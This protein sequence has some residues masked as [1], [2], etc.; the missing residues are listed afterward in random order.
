MGP[1]EIA[2]AVNTSVLAGRVQS[3][4]QLEVWIQLAALAG[5]A[6]CRWPFGTHAR[7]PLAT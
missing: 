7:S 6:D 2:T 3:L 5:I 4:R 1:S